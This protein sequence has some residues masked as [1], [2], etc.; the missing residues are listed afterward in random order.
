MLFFFAL[1]AGLSRANFESTF[2]DALLLAFLLVLIKPL[3]FSWLFSSKGKSE[4]S[5]RSGN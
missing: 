4:T 1:G 5:K 2:L 3:V